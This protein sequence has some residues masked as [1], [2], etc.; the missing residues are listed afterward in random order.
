MPHED[1]G[2]VD[3]CERSTMVHMHIIAGTE[4]VSDSEGGQCK[5]EKEG[6]RGEGIA[7]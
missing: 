7:R 5:G 4:G 1:F 6:P 2:F 3:F